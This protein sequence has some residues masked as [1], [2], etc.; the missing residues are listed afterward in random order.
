MRFKY[1]AKKPDGEIYE[2][3]VEASDRFALYADLKTSGDSV[4]YVRE[5][6]KQW[7]VWDNLKNIFSH[8]SRHDKITFASNLGAMIEAGLPLS[9]ALDV[10]EKENKNRKFKNIIAGINEGVKKGRVLSDCLKDYPEIFSPLFIAMV[11]AG[12]KSGNLSAALKVL[13]SQMQRVDLLE[14]KIRGALI[15]PAVIISIM[16]VIAVLMLIYVV[17]TLTQTFKELALDLPYSTKLV[18]W[19]SDFLQN[20]FIFSILIVSA[21]VA[22]SYL[23]GRSYFGK[24]IFHRLILRLPAIGFIVKET[25]VARTTR[26]LSSLLAAGVNVIDAFEITQ[27]VVQNTFYQKV[28]ATAKESVRLGEPIADVFKKHERLY[29]TFVSEM[30]TVGEETGRLGEMLSGVANFYENEVEQRTK[31]LSTIIE[32]ILMVIIGAA[33][34]FF[35]LSIISPMYSLINAL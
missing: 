19:T 12:E 34:G 35:A 6:R 5:M 31:D 33:V 4:L 13:S 16:F 1:K 18:I 10:E 23:L 27:S 29:P 7:L 25:N 26:T 3:V 15:Y 32:P 22:V 11:N 24:K 28:L 30:I 8:V 17:P 20:N 9:R 14:R 2:R 21:L